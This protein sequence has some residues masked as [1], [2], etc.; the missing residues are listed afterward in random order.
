MSQTY[1]LGCRQCRKHL[2]IAQAGGVGKT[3]YSAN[4]HAMG[5]L[6]DFLFEHA[7]IRSFSATTA[8]ARWSTGKR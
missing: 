5:A 7:G 6:K 1:S 3:L 4:Q 8:R 2:W